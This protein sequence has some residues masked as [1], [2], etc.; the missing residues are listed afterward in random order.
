MQTTSEDQPQQ[1]SPPAL[2]ETEA[3]QN[4]F[5][6]PKK[7]NKWLLPV[8]LVGVGLFCAIAFIGVIAAIAVP[9]IGR[10]NEAANEAKDRRNAQN[11]ASVFASATAVGLDFSN[12][13]GDVK[14]T[15]EDIVKG[16]TFSKEGSPFDGAHF[17]VPNLS[18][19]DQ[20]GASK[21]L[22]YQ[23]QLLIYIA[24]NTNQNNLVAINSIQEVAEDEDV[25]AEPEFQATPIPVSFETGPKDLF[26]R[27][28]SQTHINA[29]KLVS[30][31]DS[32]REAGVEFNAK[33]LEGAIVQ[34]IE[35][36]IADTGIY[37]GS[38]FSADEL[39]FDEVRE[40]SEFLVFEDDQ[41]LF[42][43]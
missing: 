13:N 16:K 22:A 23:D 38:R 40:A 11:I 36:G 27:I 8:I 20:E 31:Y 34:L 17:E 10:I 29:K 9:N 42:Q 39:S 19:E 28:E 18:V 35:G 43:E 15:I 37:K 21:F 33:D 30:I 1:S 2:P 24:D 6:E 32:G 3:H 26:Q 25:V 14:L 41:L 7:K 5:V 12:T 4:Y